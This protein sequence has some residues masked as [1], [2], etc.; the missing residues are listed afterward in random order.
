MTNHHRTCG[1]KPRSVGENRGNISCREDDEPDEGSGQANVEIWSDVDLDWRLK[2][3]IP[4]ELNLG[5]SQMDSLLCPGSPGLDFTTN[6]RELL[7][8][9]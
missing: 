4:I 5:S 6:D 1:H 8:G 3:I 7:V 9:S 2:A